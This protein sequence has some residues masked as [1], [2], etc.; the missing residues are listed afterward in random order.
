MNVHSVRKLSITVSVIGALV[1]GVWGAHIE[2]KARVRARAF[3]DWVQIGSPIEG[4]KREA[5]KAIDHA[6]T[7]T[8]AEST[9]LGYSGV[10]PH[11][12]HVCIVNSANGKVTGK[13]YDYFNTAL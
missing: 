9:T 2:R 12:Y 8:Q 13:V 11:S 10:I 7:F 6:V 4:V 5:D 3:C 1:I